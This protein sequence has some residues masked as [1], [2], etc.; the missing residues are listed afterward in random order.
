MTLWTLLKQQK[1][2]HCPA[3]LSLR[4]PELLIS[5]PMGSKLLE[6]ATVCP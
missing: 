3:V 4:Y 5:L 6:Q 2:W 1:H